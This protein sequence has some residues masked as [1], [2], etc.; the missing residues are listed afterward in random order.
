MGYQL[1]AKGLELLQLPIVLSH[2]LFAQSGLPDPSHACQT[3][4]HF[5]LQMDQQIRMINDCAP[6][7][8]A[9]QEGSDN[10]LNQSDRALPENQLRGL[11]RGNPHQ[12]PI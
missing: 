4:L 2:P 8:L 10:S 5:S 11:S 7:F 3:L 6:L 1:Q 9:E 12:F